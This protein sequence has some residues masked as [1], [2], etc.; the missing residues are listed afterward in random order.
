[1]FNSDMCDTLFAVD[2]KTDRTEI[3]ICQRY[4]RYDMCV[5]CYA[6]VMRYICLFG[7]CRTLMS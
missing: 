5:L 4:A 1:M 7:M 3:S 2:N 6:G